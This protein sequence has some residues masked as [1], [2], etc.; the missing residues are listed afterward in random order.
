MRRWI[1]IGIVALLG[2]GALVA[3]F[4]SARSPRTEGGAKPASSATTGLVSPTAKP[5]TKSDRGVAGP[6]AGG[7]VS[8]A[9][10]STERSRTEPVRAPDAAAPTA[11]AGPVASDRV[12]KHATL[13]VKVGAKMLDDRFARAQALA[14]F[15]GGYVEQSDQ[16]RGLASVTMR[17]PVARFDEAVARLSGLG[18]RTGLSERGDDV[19]AAFSD[20]EARIRNLAAQEGI[21]QDLMRQAR[22]IADT[23]TVQQQ[24]SQ[25]RGEI[26]QLT[27][28]RNLLDNQT[29]LAT[30]AATL[31]ANGVAPAPRE[32]GRST[33]GQAWHDAVGVTVAIVG[34][35]LVVLGALIPLGLLAALVAGG[36]LSVRRRRRVGLHP[37]GV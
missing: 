7:N 18:K 5:A 8:A 35:T 4:A 30:V 12:V 2:L 11:S 24:L 15:L 23:I 17:V 21:L 9:G 20:L 10:S 33:L 13:D 36:W 32:R 14:G 3:L 28:Q 22:S 26:E 37:A 31:H 34:G 27:G 16:S 6:A 1:G 25:V 29:S 19:S